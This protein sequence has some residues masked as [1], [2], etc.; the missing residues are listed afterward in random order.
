MPKEPEIGDEIIVFP[1]MKQQ[2]A[3]VNASTIEV[4]DEIAIHPSKDY[5][6]L[7]HGTTS[8]EVGDDV[9]VRP[10]VDFPHI[11]IRPWGCFRMQLVSETRILEGL[12]NC[13]NGWP[14]WQMIVWTV[15]EGKSFDMRCG[16]RVGE[17]TQFH[18]ETTLPQKDIWSWDPWYPWGGIRIAVSN[19]GGIN[20]T[21]ADGY[22]PSVECSEGVTKYV[23]PFL[24][25]YIFGMDDVTHV[26]TWIYTNAVLGLGQGC[27]GTFITDL[28]VCP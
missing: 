25:K 27:L 5:G 11:A 12:N 13:S 2:H 6:H 22:W 28:S 24:C 4:G 10:G 7:T 19:D 8:I 3:G 26:K 16:D 21:A 18:I 9:I 1:W 14:R 23:T 20:Y 17:G 15:P